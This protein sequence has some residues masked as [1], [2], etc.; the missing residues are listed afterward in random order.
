MVRTYQVQ[1]QQVRQQ[2]DVRQ[3]HDVDQTLAA[4]AEPIDARTDTRDNLSGEVGP[5]AQSRGGDPWVQNDNG[6]DGGG[7]GSGSGS[8]GGAGAPS[9]VPLY[10]SRDI[11]APELSK[12]EAAEEVQE[13][14]F[15]N[16]NP[17]PGLYPYPNLDPDCAVRY[18]AAA[19]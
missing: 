14:V 18:S 10:L 7:H 17:D 1:Q 5:A 19:R 12:K 9:V 15:D 2:G 6:G 13:I 8:T 16:R 4:P 11:A 3:W